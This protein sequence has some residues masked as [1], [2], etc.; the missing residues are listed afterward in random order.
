MAR[1]AIYAGSFDPLTVGP[2]DPDVGHARVDVHEE[3]GAVVRVCPRDFFLRV[4]SQVS[5][6]PHEQ[7]LLGA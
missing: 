3:V 5:V 7:V 6:A 4:A 1:K 2:L